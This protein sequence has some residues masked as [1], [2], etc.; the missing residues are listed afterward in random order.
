MSVEYTQHMETHLILF[1][2]ITANAA[3][4]NLVDAFFCGRFAI[5]SINPI[6]DIAAIVASCL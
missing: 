1:I 6:L 5:S 2:A 4:R 3:L